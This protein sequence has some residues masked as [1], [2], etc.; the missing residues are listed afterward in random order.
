MNKRKRINLLQ[1]DSDDSEEIQDVS[2]FFFL[3]F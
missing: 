1:E 3:F 2:S